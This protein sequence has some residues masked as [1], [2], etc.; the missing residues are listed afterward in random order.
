MAAGNVYHRLM[1]EQ[2]RDTNVFHVSGN[3]HGS[4]GH[5]NGARRKPTEDVTV[6][7]D[8]SSAVGS[9]PRRVFCGPKAWRGRRLWRN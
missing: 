3:G 5:V 4:N 9:A 6:S 1:A 2:A 8:A 7:I